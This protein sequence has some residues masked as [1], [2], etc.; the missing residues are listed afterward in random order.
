MSEPMI[1]LDRVSRTFG[2]WQRQK[3]VEGSS[4]AGYVVDKARLEAAAAG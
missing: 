1:V 4:R 2:E 3:I